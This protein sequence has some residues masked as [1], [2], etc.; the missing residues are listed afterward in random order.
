MIL[1]APGIVVT[2][3][4][5]DEYPATHEIAGVPV[6]CGYCR[7][8]NG[9][10]PVAL[11]SGEFRLGEITVYTERA[12]PTADAEAACGALT[13]TIL[14]FIQSGEPDFSAVTP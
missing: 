9:G 10:K 7:A 6:A 8:N 1:A 13:D 2:D 4:I 11:F 12:A 5:V 3:T 14:Q